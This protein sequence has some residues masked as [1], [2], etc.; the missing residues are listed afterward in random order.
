MK[1]FIIV[2][3]SIVAGASGYLLT[4]FWFQPILRYREI[5]HQVFSDLIF[6]ANAINADGMNEK[7]KER[8]GQRVESNRKHSAELTACYKDMPIWFRKWLER[9]G[10]KPMDAANHLMGLSN[11]YEYDPADKRIEK[12]KEHLKILTN[13][14]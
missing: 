7:M 11:T 3:I 2:L 12:I 10:E 13:V 6:Y 9:N 4:T 14:V 1:E 5:K 8:M